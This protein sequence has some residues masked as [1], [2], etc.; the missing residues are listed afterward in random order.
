MKDDPTPVFSA[1]KKEKEKKITL[2]LQ[3]ALVAC[4]ALFADQLTKAVAFYCLP[5]RGDV[6][7]LIDGWLG[8]SHV[9]NDAIAFGIG[10][11]NRAFMIVIMVVTAILMAGIPVLAFKAFGKNVP[12]QVCLAV[13]EGGAAGNFIDRLFVK[14]EAGVAVVRDFVNLERFGFANCNIADFCITF[15][16]AALVFVILFIGPQSVFPLTRKWRDEAK[17]AEAQKER[18]RAEK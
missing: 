8:F 15:G 3:F 5:Q 13:I 12:A 16:A 18:E 7:W 2:M 11:G 6:Y 9:E 1:A 17:K 14:N 10:S 4:I